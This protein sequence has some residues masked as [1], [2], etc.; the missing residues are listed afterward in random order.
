MVRS[1]DSGPAAEVKIRQQPNVR[2]EAQV[3]CCVFF[4]FLSFLFLS[5]FPFFFMKKKKKKLLHSLSLR[6]LSILESS[7]VPDYIPAPLLLAVWS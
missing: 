5:L 2:D 4:F 3:F 7:G 1:G 6:P